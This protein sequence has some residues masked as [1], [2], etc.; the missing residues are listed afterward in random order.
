MDEHHGKLQLLWAVLIALLLSSLGAGYYLLA[1]PEEVET[2]DI[3]NESAQVEKQQ[4]IPKSTTYV[5][6]RA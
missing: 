6:D 5:A 1:H 3:E 4:L 2:D